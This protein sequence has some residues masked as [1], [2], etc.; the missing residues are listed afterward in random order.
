MGEQTFPRLHTRIF[1]SQAVRGHIDYYHRGR[2][3]FDQGAGLRQIALFGTVRN[4][5]REAS[6]RH[7]L[8]NL[9]PKTT[10]NVFFA[11]NHPRG[12][13]FHSSAAWLSTRYNSFIAASSLG[14]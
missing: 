2:Q 7:W 12:A 13:R 4:L 8:T 11:S 14:K 10:A 3:S 5:V 9:S 1:A 6:C